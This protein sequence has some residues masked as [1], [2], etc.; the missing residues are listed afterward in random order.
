[1]SFQK[2]LGT[3]SVARIEHRI[4]WDGIKLEAFLLL[5]VRLPVRILSNSE[6]VTSFLFKTAHKFNDIDRKL[7]HTRL[8][9]KIAQYQLRFLG[10]YRA[11]K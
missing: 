6:V 4:Y 1:M 11:V 10:K 9:P 5:S 3:L 2:N 7:C 8:A